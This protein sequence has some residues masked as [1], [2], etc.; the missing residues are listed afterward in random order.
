MLAQFCTWKVA[1]TKEENNLTKKGSSNLFL[2]ELDILKPNKDQWAAYRGPLVAPI[3]FT[4]FEKFGLGS[5]HP[6]S[7][8]PRVAFHLEIMLSAWFRIYM[9]EADAYPCCPGRCW[10]LYLWTLLSFSFLVTVTVGGKQHLLGL[11][12]TAGQVYFYYLDLFLLSWFI[13]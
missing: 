5:A 9:D 10:S 4:S 1:Q 11:Y 2:Q 6:L 8:Q 13:Q 7:L 3:L 12:D